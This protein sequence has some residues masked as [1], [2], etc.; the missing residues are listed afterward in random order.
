MSDVS[1]KGSTRFI[2]AALDSIYHDNYAV[3]DFYNVHCLL[4][5]RQK[6][7]AGVGQLL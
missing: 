2:K 3:V 5:C 1:G 6:Q 7:F 4:K